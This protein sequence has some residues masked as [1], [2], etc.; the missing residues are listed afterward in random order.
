MRTPR[1]HAKNLPTLLTPTSSRVHLSTPFMALEHRSYRS[2]LPLH[3][4]A[5]V[6]L[7]CAIGGFS[8][9]Y[10]LLP[11]ALI[12]PF[13]FQFSVGAPNVAPVAYSLPPLVFTM[14]MIG[15]ASAHEGQHMVKSV[16]MHASRDV[17]MHLMCSQDAVDILTAVLALVVRPAHNV[18]VT[19]WI[20]T[21]E[22]VSR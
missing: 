11:T 15:A 20:V 19:L 7:L 12:P 5:A 22:Q 1:P 4:A 17:Q 6:I 14:V 18:D 8:M 13:R 10:L 9:L 2:T 16:L 21:P 3:S